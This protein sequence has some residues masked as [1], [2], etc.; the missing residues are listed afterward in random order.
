MKS[1]ARSE[2]SLQDASRSPM[3]WW[4]SRGGGGRQEGGRRKVVGRQCTLNFWI[5]HLSF[6]ICH[7]SFVTADRRVCERLENEEMPNDKWKMEN[8]KWKIGVKR[9]CP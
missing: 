5:F 6:V 4:R 9:H 8:G 7:L 2:T 3:R 1:N